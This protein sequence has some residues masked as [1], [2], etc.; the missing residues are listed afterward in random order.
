MHTK[1]PQVKAVL[2]HMLQFGPSLNKLL[3]YLQDYFGK[4]A[5]LNTTI[6]D[7]NAP[8]QMQG[9]MTSKIPLFV[10]TIFVHIVTVS[11][12]GH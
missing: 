5:G 1:Y 11:I 7:E 8:Y 6:K 12:K 9:I 4:I 3:S 10:S 2:S